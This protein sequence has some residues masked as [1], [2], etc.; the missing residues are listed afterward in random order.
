MV[1]KLT[2]ELAKMK[3]GS[4]LEPGHTMDPPVTQAYFQKVRGYVD[5]GVEAGTDRVVDGRGI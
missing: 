2:V 5:L 3:I 4:G 1:E